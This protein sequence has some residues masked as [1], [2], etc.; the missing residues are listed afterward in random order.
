MTAQRRLNTILLTVFGVVAALLA[1]VGIYGLTAY[2]VA[3]RTRELGVRIALGA[4]AAR[5]LRLV[6]GEG[7]LLAGAGVALGLSAAIVLGESMSTML[8]GV[9]VDGPGDVR[10]HRARR[11][12]HSARRQRRAG[13]ACRADRPRPI[14][15]RGRLTSSQPDSS[16]IRG[17]GTP[18]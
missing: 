12:A 15:Q 2:S 11:H 3:Q 10:G 7:L 14:S 1:A 16:G 4:S 13:A 8:Y 5:V 9:S 17:R 6:A 18:T